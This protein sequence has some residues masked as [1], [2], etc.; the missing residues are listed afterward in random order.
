MIYLYIHI[1]IY[2]YIYIHM[3]T[4]IYIYK[5]Y[6]SWSPHSPMSNPRWL[7]NRQAC[8]ASSLPRRWILRD[9]RD[10]KG[11]NFTGERSEHIWKS[12]E[13][14]GN[15]W[16]IH[17][18]I[19]W[20]KKWTYMENLLNIYGKS[21]DI[22]Y[23]YMYIIIYIYNYIYIYRWTSMRI[24]GK[25]YLVY[26]QWWLI[27][28]IKS[29]WLSESWGV[30]ITW[31]WKKSCSSMDDEQGYPHRKPPYMKMVNMVNGV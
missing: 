24:Y 23:I 20:I 13:N 11:Q 31:S 16:K 14:Y 12:M 10:T 26:G 30:P 17:M 18:V 25:I 28:G 22:I 8:S 2:T 1:Y 19:I 27:M 7:P 15:A 6:T 4:Y 9:P 5:L 3:Y 29:R 21:I